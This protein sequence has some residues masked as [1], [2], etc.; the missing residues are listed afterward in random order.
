[1]DG[2]TSER[3]SY[4]N[5]HGVGQSLSVTSVQSRDMDSMTF[6]GLLSAYH[7]HCFTANFLKK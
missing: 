2:Q 5:L 3:Y 7:A 1:M 4:T 6:M